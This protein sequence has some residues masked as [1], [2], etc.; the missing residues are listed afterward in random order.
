MFDSMKKITTRLKSSNFSRYIMP[1][2]VHDRGFRS[3]Q[4]RQSRVE[5][6]CTSA[7]LVEDSVVRYDN[8]D[9]GVA[10]SFVQCAFAWIVWWRLGPVLRNELPGAVST[11]SVDTVDEQWPR[12]LGCV[13]GAR[14]SGDTPSR[15]HWHGWR[16]SIPSCWKPSLRGILRGSPP[17]LHHHLRSR[18]DRK[19]QARVGALIEVIAV[20]SFMMLGRI[21][22]C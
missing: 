6:H 10:E 14:P 12:W 21:R 16:E 11:R 2:I 9:F 8:R 3:R 13:L 1:G 7:W 15:G 4:P 20:V 17:P 22:A 5:N 18:C 19:G